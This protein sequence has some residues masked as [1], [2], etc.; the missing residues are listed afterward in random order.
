MKKA[1]VFFVFLTL[2]FSSYS[3]NSIILSNDTTVCGMQNFT[4]YAIS[5]AVDS[6]VT[7]DVY[8]DVVDLGFNFNFYGNT[9]DKML[10]SSNGY[11]TFDTTNANGYSPWSIALPIPNPGNQPENAIMVTW[12]DTDP[13][14][15]GAIYFGSYG[16]SPNKVYI[17]TWCAIPMFDCTNLIY[18]SQLRIYEGSNKIEMFL[19]IACSVK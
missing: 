12:Q 3:Q 5:S 18:T 17:V 9:Y 11:V 1:I 16:V 4:L 2:N 7:D 10:I 8:T 14:F 6:L 19:Q 13:G 15:G